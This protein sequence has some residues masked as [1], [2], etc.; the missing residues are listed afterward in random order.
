MVGGAQSETPADYESAGL[1]LYR[2]SGLILTVQVESTSFRD[3]LF[4]Y[5]L[6]GAADG[7][8]SASRRFIENRWVAPNVEP[9]DPVFLDYNFVILV[10][11]GKHE[12]QPHQHAPGYDNSRS[13]RASARS[14]EHDLQTDSSAPN[15]SF[16]GWR[17]LAS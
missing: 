13:C 14:Y 9:H 8:S 12:A 11:K 2:S 3:G 16:Q 5:W 10:L 17:Q 4:S 7:K 15:S 6:S 1:V